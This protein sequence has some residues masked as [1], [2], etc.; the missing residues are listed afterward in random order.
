[1]TVWDDQAHGPECSLRESVHVGAK[2]TEIFFHGALRGMD[3]MLRG[4]GARTQAQ[5]EARAVQ[6]GGQMVGITASAVNSSMI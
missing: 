1:M 2:S 5:M 4:G 3:L 6:A